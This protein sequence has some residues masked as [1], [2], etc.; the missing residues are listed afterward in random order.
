MQTKECPGWIWR[1]SVLSR[2]FRPNR[3]AEILPIWDKLTT[4][5]LRAKTNLGTR[6]LLDFIDRL[7]SSYIWPGDPEWESWCKWLNAFCTI[8]VV[9]PFMFLILYFNPNT[10]LQERWG[11]LLIKKL[12][13]VLGATGG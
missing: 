7:P 2:L 3:K 9:L 13:A 1:C 6:K 4:G 12:I 11:L 10:N 8:Y 5:L